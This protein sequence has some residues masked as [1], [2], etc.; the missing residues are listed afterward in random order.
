MTVEKHLGKRHEVAQAT[1]SPEFGVC[2]G[3][4][5]RTAALRA[6]AGDNRR[7]V[8]EQSGKH[9]TG[10]VAPP[11]GAGAHDGNTAIRANRCE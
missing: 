7:P 8:P 3:H 9:R 6:D 2:N 10:R 4:K 11:V 1:S 5:Q